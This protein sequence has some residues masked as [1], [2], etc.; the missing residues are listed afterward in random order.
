MDDN[1]DDIFPG[2]SPI[3]NRELTLQA[4]NDMITLKQD[5]SKGDNKILTPNSADIIMQ[6]GD[7]VNLI[8]SLAALAWIVI[9]QSAIVTTVKSQD[10]GDLDSAFVVNFN[11]F[12]DR[13][14]YG[15]QTGGG[16]ILSFINIPPNLSTNLKI[17]MTP[18]NAANS[19]SVGGTL[20]YDSG[21]DPY[22]I[23]PLATNDFLSIE[24]ESPDQANV[25]II[26]V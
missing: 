14:L 6:T 12:D 18:A 13:Q 16:I 25:N 17:Y 4:G 3:Q 20:I 7:L 26:S 24:F 5:F 15:N 19:L 22:S 10:L 9:G 11:N 1:L 2:T 8:Y 23:K 21:N